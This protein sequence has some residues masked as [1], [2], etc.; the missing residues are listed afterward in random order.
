MSDHMNVIGTVSDSY[1]K[2]H[3]LKSD[4]FRLFFHTLFF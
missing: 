3:C 2:F 1:G 4:R